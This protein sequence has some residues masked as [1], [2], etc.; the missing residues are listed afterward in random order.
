MF[1]M[2]NIIQ[3][4][5]KISKNIFLSNFVDEKFLTKLKKDYKMLSKSEVIKIKNLTVQEWLPIE[6]IYNDRI[7]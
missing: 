4:N 2:K 5:K 3:K 7:C 1:K 6:K